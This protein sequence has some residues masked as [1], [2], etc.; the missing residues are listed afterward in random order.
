[1]KVELLGWVCNKYP[2][3]TSTTKPVS[4]NLNSPG[5]KLTVSVHLKSNAQAPEVS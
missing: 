5:S 1:L 4:T 2:D 3:G